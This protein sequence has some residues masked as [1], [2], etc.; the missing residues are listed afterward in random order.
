MV[1]LQF[2]FLYSD[3]GRDCGSDGFALVYKRRGYK[4]DVDS[5]ECLPIRLGYVSIAS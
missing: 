1:F 4:V 3:G 2:N 5:T